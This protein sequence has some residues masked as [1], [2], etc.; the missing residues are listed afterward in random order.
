M[1]YIA[2]LARRLRPGRTYEDFLEAWYPNKGF[3]WTGSGPLVARNVADAREIL[4]Y[5]QFELPEGAD[6][7]AEIAR[8]AQQEAVRHDR[9]AEVVEPADFR[10][11][12][13]I[14]DEFDFSTDDTVE[15]GRPAFFSRS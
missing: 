12:F 14:T 3:G 15:A 4:T 6:L 1:N 2:V 9:I 5:A 7:D 13:Q 11:I 8:V 10:G